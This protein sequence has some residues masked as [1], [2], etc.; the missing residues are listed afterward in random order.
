MGLF[1]SIKKAI[2]SDVNTNTEIMNVNGVCFDSRHESIML[3]SIY[4]KIML[5]C[6]ERASIPEGVDKSHYTLTQYNSISPAKKGLVSLLV[7]GMVKRDRVFYQKELIENGSYLFTKIDN[8]DVDEIGADILE[9][10]FTGFDESRVLELLLQLL[11]NVF[12]SLSNGVVISAALLLKIHKLSDM[13]DNSQNRAALIEQVEQLNT[14]LSSGRAGYIDAES[15]LAFTSFDSKPATEAT[16][17]IFGLISMVT[18]LPSSYLFSDVVGGLGDM[19]KSEEN[20]LNVA[21][22]SYFNDIMYGSLYSTFDKVFEYKQ[23]ITDIKSMVELF[24]WLETTELIT[25]EEKRRVIVNNTTLS[26]EGL[27]PATKPAPAKVEVSK[28]EVV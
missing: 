22:Q 9:L 17:F 7:R 4:K 14:S 5:A 15:E 13:I 16:S 18:G 21:L 11:T 28:V 23:I 24:T 25:E 10:D 3:T 19:S 26:L 6:A 1:N 20:R 2:N 12:R 27:T 8:Q